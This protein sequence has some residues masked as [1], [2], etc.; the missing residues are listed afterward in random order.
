MKKYKLITASE[1]QYGRKKIIFVDDVQYSLVSVKKILKENYEIFPAESSLILFKILENVKPNIIL[2]DVNMP[3]MDGYKIIKTLKTDERY[4]DIPVVFLTS[5]NDKQSVVK[6]LNLGA[7]D[8]IVKPFET[9]KL[10]ECIEKH[11]AAAHE[12]KEE[13]I[14]PFDVDIGIDINDIKPKILVVDDVASALKTIRY[15]LDSSY[16][17]YTLS[18]SEKVIEFLKENKVDLIMLDYLMPVI[19]GFE[20]IPMI[21]QLSHYRKTPI[22]MLTSE[23][24]LPALNAAIALGASDFIV[25]PYKSAELIE[26]IA[27][28]LKR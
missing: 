22:I 13:K 2:L 10:I 15:T 27:K 4:A 5:V 25:K 18:E 26:K 3:G 16:D 23:G 24:T 1:I 19:N 8:Y 21:R 14:D 9:S 6:G 17:V 28:H 12:K 11:T 20:L 7:V